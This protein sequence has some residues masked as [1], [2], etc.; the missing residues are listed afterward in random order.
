MGW[1][2]TLPCP[3][4]ATTEVPSKR[5]GLKQKSCS[6]S[7]QQ[8]RDHSPAFRGREMQKKTFSSFML[9][10]PNQPHQ[11]GGKTRCSLPAL[12]AHSDGQVHAPFLNAAPP[13]PIG[14]GTLSVPNNHPKASLSQH[15]WEATTALHSPT[16][17]RA[18]SGMAQR[19][20][21]AGS[22]FSFP[23]PISRLFLGWQPQ[24]EHGM[25]SAGTNGEGDAAVWSTSHR[26]VEP[27]QGAAQRHLALKLPF[28]GEYRS[29]IC[30][31]QPF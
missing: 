29:H 20:K 5:R 27:A 30:T 17:R 25:V 6:C 26:A 11:P 31:Q 15:C 23:R 12:P 3:H 16:R 9:H 7:S 8:N 18:G 10:Q 19:S 1:L 28:L 2:F 21:P 13:S 24:L 22:C 4:G 14:L